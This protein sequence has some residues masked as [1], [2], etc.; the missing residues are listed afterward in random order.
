MSDGPLT[1]LFDRTIHVL[2]KI[3]GREISITDLHVRISFSQAQPS[4][5]LGEITGNYSQAQQLESLGFQDGLIFEGIVCPNPICAISS[6][7]VSL[8]S[9][10]KRIFAS[11]DN[12][13]F[14]D[15][16]ATIAF[17]E[18][19]ISEKINTQ[20]SR[21]SH[22]YLAGPKSAWPVSCIRNK[23][24]DGTI[25]VSLRNAELLLGELNNINVKVL[26][27]YRYQDL[28]GSE[29]EIIKEILVIDVTEISP[30]NLSREEFVLQ[31][32][33]LVDDLCLLASFL[34][35][36]W[37]DWYRYNSVFSAS[38]YVDFVRRIR[39]L[40]EVSIRPFELLVPAIKRGEFLSKALSK[41]RELKRKG[42]DLTLC[43]T[44][45]ISGCAEDKISARFIQLYLCLEKLVAIFVKEGTTIINND[46]FD[47]LLIRLEDLVKETIQETSK[48]LIFLGKLKNINNVPLAIRLERLLTMY[49]VEWT[50]LYPPETTKMSFTKTRNA[51]FHTPRQLDPEF[52]LRESERLRILL[53]QLILSIL[54][55]REMYNPSS[56]QFVQTERQ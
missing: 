27:T 26:P 39:S 16:I 24:F 3:T 51:L 33:E 12:N 56:L 13:K 31:S 29:S 42:Q 1:H 23:N 47:E 45:F 25:E 21:A 46:L 11:K 41:F 5:I 44:L 6:N 40:P 54:S 20:Q 35:R 30:Q 8:S 22:F 53:E 55:C 50:N 36:S 19:Y 48:G 10:G 49:E 38:E 17:D 34:S 9:I 52:L 18:I 14:Y 28:S 2:A 4:E 15:R 37:I 43:M 32:K 7:K